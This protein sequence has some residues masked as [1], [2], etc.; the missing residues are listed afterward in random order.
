MGNVQLITQH[1]N[2][3]RV[4]HVAQVNL[5]DNVVGQPGTRLELMTDRLQHR[6]PEPIPTMTPVLHFFLF[7][8]CFV[9]FLFIRFHN[10]STTK[11]TIRR[12]G[13]AT[14]AAVAPCKSSKMR[15]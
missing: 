14:M 5:V 10:M 11:A 3:G 8:F 12:R 9:F 2:V 7:F 15:Q 1:F 13:A 6:G 4:V